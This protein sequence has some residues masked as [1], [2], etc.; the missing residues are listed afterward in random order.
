VNLEVSPMAGAEIDRLLAAIYA[1]PPALV[2]K[3]KQVMK[4]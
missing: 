4:N 1:S 2:E 3:A